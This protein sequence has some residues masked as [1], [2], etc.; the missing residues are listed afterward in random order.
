M[1]RS[2]MAVTFDPAELTLLGALAQEY[3]SIE[4]AVA[5][6]AAAPAGLGLPKG[7]VHVVSDVHGEYRKLRHVINNASGNLRPMVESLFH[8]RLT[9]NQRRELLNVLYYPRE[10]MEF[11]KPM[12]LDASVRR[13]WVRRTLRFQFELVRLLARGYRRPW[14]TNFFPPQRG[15]LFAEL[16]DEPV[17]RPDAAYVNAMI[18]ALAEHG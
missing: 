5:E 7:V 4:A 2:S 3:P 8:D 10:T 11:L 6:I 15:E 16:L 18:D 1:K 13:D 14:V 9:E 12:L 17:A